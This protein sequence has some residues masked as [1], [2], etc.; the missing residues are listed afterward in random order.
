MPMLAIPALWRLYRRA[1]RG[2]GP[3]LFSDRVLRELDISYIVQGDL[4]EIPA[5]GPAIIVANHPFG[6]ADGLVLASLLARRRSDARLLAN[7][8]LKVIPELRDQLLFVD[9]FGNG[10]GSCRSRGGTRAIVRNTQPMRMAVRWLR[11][12][13]CLCVFP[14]GTVSHF[15]WRHARITD[16]AWHASIGRLARLTGAPIVPCFIEGKNGATFQLAGC[17]HPLLRTLLLPRQLLRARGT[18]IN[19]HIGRAVDA[20]TLDRHDGTAALQLRSRT[21]AIDARA[22]VRREVAAVMLDQTLVRA[23]TFSVFWTRASQA[24]GLLQEIGREREIAF[25]GVQEGT[26]RDIDLDAF[27]QRYL[28]LCLWD[29]ERHELAGAYRMRPVETW[30]AGRDDGL[31]TQTLF[32]FDRRLIAAL[33]PAIELGRAFIRQP[34]QKHHAALMLLWAGIGRFVAAHRRYR[35]LFGAVSIGQTYSPPVR[36]AIMSHL[37]Q[38]AFQPDL[39]RLVVPR[40]PPTED[41]TAASAAPAARAQMPVLLRQYLKLHARVLGFN[42]DPAFG[43]VLDALI[44]VDLTRTPETIL[45]RYMGP[46]QAREFLAYHRM[47]AAADAAPEDLRCRRSA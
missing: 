18:N 4:R 34:Y 11:N 1:R 23:D 33:A 24:P 27:D 12:G 39:A 21:Y 46:D 7:R 17:V 43:N 28:H 14:A 41:A 38:H 5:A 47:M 26:G 37:R 29:R 20:T 9:V 10:D 40:N 36:G 2:A 42:V 19:I 22:G 15:Q 30:S 3:A 13:G 16:P 31:Y 6:A 8:M 25:R 32:Q 35:H 45:R 44:V